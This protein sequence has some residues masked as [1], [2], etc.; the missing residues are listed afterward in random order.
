M[1]LFSG[2]NPSDFCLFIRF[3][4]CLC[5]NPT[6]LFAFIVTIYG[7][8]GTT[9]TTMHHVRSSTTRVE[10]LILGAGWTSEFLIPLL[11][12][13]DVSFAATSRNGRGETIPFNFDPSSRDVEQYQTLPDAATVLITFPVVENVRA[14]VDGYREMRSGTGRGIS[15]NWIQLGSTGSFIQVRLFC[16]I[17]NCSPVLTW[18]LDRLQVGWIGTQV[19]SL[20]PE[21]FK[22]QNYLDMRLLLSCTLPGFGEEREI[23]FIGPKGLHQ[24]RVLSPQ[25]LAELCHRNTIIRSL[26]LCCRVPSI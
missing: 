17:F 24:I 3:V 14:L 25:R 12:S 8:P 18:H 20:F 10:V 19:S 7:T 22:K 21:V 6:R 5:P 9:R 16:C 1:N 15:V 26:N 4:M 2:R 23:R 13:N 11:Q